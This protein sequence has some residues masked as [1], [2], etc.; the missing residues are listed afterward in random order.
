MENIFRQYDYKE[1]TIKGN[2]SEYEE[3]STLGESCQSLLQSC[4]APKTN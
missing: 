2:I 4:N 3:K 1:V